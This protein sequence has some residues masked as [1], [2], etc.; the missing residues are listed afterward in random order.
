MIYLFFWGGGLREWFSYFLSNSI[1]RNETLEIKNKGLPTQQTIVTGQ[2][3]F[4]G[5]DGYKYII[6]YIIDK[7]GNHIVIDKFSIHRIPPNLL[8]SLIG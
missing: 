1:N 5:A 3:G 4:K 7:S 8:K 6:K 2:Y